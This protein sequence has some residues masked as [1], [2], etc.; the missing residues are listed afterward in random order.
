MIKLAKY[1]ILW[2][3]EPTFPD[4]VLGHARIRE[5]LK[6]YNIGV[7]TGEVMANRIMHKQFC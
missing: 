5:G 2:I 3:E 7:A 4:D 6:P 1:N